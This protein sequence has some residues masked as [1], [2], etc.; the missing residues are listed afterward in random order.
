MLLS[1]YIVIKLLFCAEGSSENH[2]AEIECDKLQ[3]ELESHVDNEEIKMEE[4]L[5]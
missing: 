1:N 2:Q 5:E 4:P 3:A